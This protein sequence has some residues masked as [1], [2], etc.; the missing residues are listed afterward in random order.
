[1][2]LSLEAMNI[3]K[4]EGIMGGEKEEKKK[5]SQS[6]G[7][8]KE[9]VSGH[10]NVESFY[11]FFEQD[12]EAFFR[13]SN[14]RKMDDEL[15]CFFTR[16]DEG[17]HI[18]SKISIPSIVPEEKVKKSFAAPEEPALSFKEKRKKAHKIKESERELKERIPMAGN[19]DPEN[20]T[21]YTGNIIKTH[22][23]MVDKLKVRED[24]LSVDDE[25]SDFEVY[26]DKKVADKSELLAM[27][28]QPDMFRPDYF[29][30]H[31]DVIFKKMMHYDDLYKTYSKNG[32]EYDRLTEAEKL[33]FKTFKKTY[34]LMRECF[35]SALRVHN[36]SLRSSKEDDLFDERDP[37]AFVNV[38][39]DEC[40]EYETK[41][42]SEA[43]KEAIDRLK[44]FLS[45][46]DVKT[47]YEVEDF[48]SR[49]A[50]AQRKVLTQHAEEFMKRYDLVKGVFRDEQTYVEAQ[51]Y[52]KALDEKKNLPV[53]AKDRK[54]I[55]FALS[56]YLNLS[57]LIAEL[58][59]RRQG[60]LIKRDDLAAKYHGEDKIP[61][62]HPLGKYV[63]TELKNTEDRL[64]LYKRQ[65]EEITV[66]LDSVLLGRDKTT[67]A[68][69]ALKVTYGFVDETMTQNTARG[70]ATLLAAT[71]REKDRLLE[72]KLS[73]YFRDS[74]IDEKNMDRIYKLL[75]NEPFRL[76]MSDKDPKEKN[77]ALIKLGLF[78]N[79]KALSDIPEVKKISANSVMS[80]L[81]KW[82]MPEVKKYLDA[83][84][85]AGNA[86]TREE[87]LARQ[88][89]FM[90]LSFTGNC[91]IRLGSV[92]SDDSSVSFKDRLLKG[93][94]DTS[95]L[96]KLFP[97]RQKEVEGLL[98][99][100][101][102]A[103]IGMTDIRLLENPESILTESEARA[104]K[105]GVY[106]EGSTEARIEELAKRMIYNGQLMQST[107][108]SVIFNDTYAADQC[109]VMI[110]AKLKELDD[111]AAAVKSQDE[112]VSKDEA[113]YKTVLRDRFNDMLTRYEALEQK[114]GYDIPKIA[115]IMIKL[116]EAWDDF[117]DF[118]YDRELLE[119][120]G[121]KVLKKDDSKDQRLVNLVNYYSTYGEIFLIKIYP[122]ICSE[123]AKDVEGLMNHSSIKGLLTKLEEYR[124]K[125]TGK[126][127]VV[128]SD[129]PA[130][131]AEAETAN[132]TE[133]EVKS[134]GPAV[135][136]LT[137]KGKMES[138]RK[139]LLS[140]SSKNDTE[141]LSDIGNRKL[142]AAKAEYYG[143]GKETLLYR[144]RGDKEA[145][146]LY[147]TSDPA[148]I[149]I[150]EETIDELD[151][152]YVGFKDYMTKRKRLVDKL[153]GLRK[154][155][156][157]QS[158]EAPQK[159][160]GADGNLVPDA[161]IT[162]PKELYDP[163]RY[164]EL[165]GVSYCG[166]QTTNNGCWSVSMQIQLKYRGIDMTQ[167]EVRLYR[168]AE[169]SADELSD[170]MICIGRDEIGSPVEV[171]EIMNICRDNM[172]THSV[173]MTPGL[174]K[175]V[176]LKD[177]S[178]PGVQLVKLT[179]EERIAA[180]TEYFR[181]SIVD[182]LVRHGSPV[183]LLRGNHI[184]TIFAI[185][186]TKIKYYDSISPRRDG[187]GY[188]DLKDICR[189]IESSDRG[190]V[191]VVWFEQLPMGDKALEEAW[192]KTGT[193][194]SG[195][196]RKIDET[197][198][199]GAYDGFNHMARR[200]T[201]RQSV[202]EKKEA[203]VESGIMRKNAAYEIGDSVFLPKTMK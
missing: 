106:G 124:D 116:N 61:A 105:S 12:R 83:K 183:S 96:H 193:S 164:Y 198:T 185:E 187:I 168:P 153:E 190:K 33:A 172:V 74:G 88:A 147:L 138:D 16:H 40:T 166:R 5:K 118:R 75:K 79:R 38:K 126:A 140:S 20:V 139:K 169:I 115:M 191:Q 176:S 34:E 59:L 158:F 7:G 1:M 131:A 160:V 26:D 29:G 157:K 89:E 145:V 44:K 76:M 27:E 162:D 103:A 142:S 77:A 101:R 170:V 200:Y 67:G 55:S 68:T 2:T 30:E 25:L 69:G 108:D 120:E 58:E 98:L 159:A 99:Q 51:K 11:S 149:E 133:T 72:S 70:S 102:G 201:D 54:G 80:D 13:G 53:I 43:N 46:S 50:D 161:I 21:K 150:S 104:I 42:P 117:G 177:D 49:Y 107:S 23:E 122:L 135:K 151:K 136:Y 130:P 100:S 48:V 87:L 167:E 94:S 199:N 22:S 134:E 9:T 15:K 152:K 163:D 125:L 110:S 180:N 174:Q 181:R 195:T 28:Y 189:Q 73:D 114:Y 65:V 57:E 93:N 184:V 91:L 90:R 178:N 97:A 113:K 171:S 165:P 14:I 36:L 81:K 111:K 4:G 188:G 123:V 32:D 119:K 10:K 143:E 52:M 141:D 24:S 197:D 56:E 179:E 192:K 156:D 37:F 95:V 86:V 109:A 202:T 39:P 175:G 63:L 19:Y 82:I 121:G 84:L 196:D 137:G 148:V 71:I 129:Q 144:I 35:S 132:A 154:Q 78:A 17:S 45:E 203:M 66:L 112:K 194:Y 3:R 155:K 173:E 31:Y 18:S 60:Y 6:S 146:A 85:P 64:A 62:K 8:E 186:G 47:A 41:K 128:K 182:G 92:D 127:P